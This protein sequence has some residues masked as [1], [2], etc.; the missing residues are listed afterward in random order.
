MFFALCLQAASIFVLALLVLGWRGSDPALGFLYGGGLAL[1]GTGLLVWRWHR[2][3]HDYHCDGAR[4]LRSFHRSALERFFVVGILFAAGL[5]GLRLAPLP[6]LLGLIVGQFAWVIA[7][8]V[9]K[10]E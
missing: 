1:L 3:R 7:L 6:M 10:T 9:L 4:H 8:A 5:A 2:G